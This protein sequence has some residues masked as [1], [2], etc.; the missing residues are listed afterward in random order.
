MIHEGLNSP[1]HFLRWVLLPV[2]FLQTDNKPTLEGKDEG[3][4]LWS[5]S[6]LA[7]KK[8][9]PG[10]YGLIKD[11]CFAKTC[12]LMSQSFLEA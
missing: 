7:W 5:A 11:S 6:S 12:N 1:M 8:M 4:S 2:P 10:R 3:S 9:Y